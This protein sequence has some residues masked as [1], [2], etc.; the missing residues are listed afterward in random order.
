[1]KKNY[2][3]LFAVLILTCSASLLHAQQ[4]SEWVKDVISA[5]GGKF[6]G[7]PPYTDFATVQAYDPSTQMV[8]VF[9][10]IYTQ[11]VQDVVI[12]G[13]IAY[14]AAQ[15]S[16][17]MYNLDT[18]ERMAAIADS[19][20]SKLYIYKNALIVSKQYPVTR[21]FVEVLDANNLALLAL[22][23]NI[24]GECAGIVAADDIV[25]VAVNG[26]F[27]GTSGKLAAINPNTW[28]LSNEYDLGQPAVGIYNLFSFGGY[29]FS[30]N[31]TPYGGADT[32]SVSR[33]NYL[34][35]DFSTKVLGTRIGDGF[36]I[37]DNLLYLKMNEGMGSYNLQTQSI[38]DTTIVPDPGSLLYITIHA[39]AIDYVNS[40]AYL[41][42]GNRNTFGIGIVTTL[43]GDSITSFPTGINAEAIAIDYRTPTGT[44]SLSSTP[45]SI[46]PN[47][48]EDHIIIR[49]SEEES[50]HSLKI[51]DLTGRTILSRNI[52]GFEKYI[53][54]DCSE[55][56]SGLYVI[57]FRTSDGI[58]TRKFIK[59]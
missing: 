28:T 17:I 48:A 46:T 33:F 16:I 36:G 39:G 55:F 15:D 11:S 44:T 59:K 58:Q 38:A 47:P 54:V 10:T 5:N 3:F 41:H 31:K 32:G 56:P 18:Y 37:K 21:F 14:V 1:M 12:N 19:G 24:S 53:K 22:V 52:S 57:S 27:M 49:L 40:R 29:I 4:K 13:N 30:V 25:Y 45:L 42:I 43:T 34:T 50:F 51:Y 8:D 26:G 2:F 20:L 35:G 7:T 6:E 23:Q 9:N